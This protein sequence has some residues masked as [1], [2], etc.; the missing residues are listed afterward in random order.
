MTSSPQICAGCCHVFPPQTPE[1]TWCPDCGRLCSA[2]DPP[3]EEPPPPDEYPMT[4]EER[5]RWRQWY[6]LFLL[7]SPPMAMLA[8]PM[9]RTLRAWVPTAWQPLVSFGAP[10]M[11]FLLPVVGASGAAFCVAKSQRPGRTKAQFM[12]LVLGSGAGILLGQWMLM[13]LS[14]AIFR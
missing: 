3:Y 2:N 6:W 5:R 8:V 11:V 14:M 13:G 7:V 4:E 12:A 10:I 1:P 9:S